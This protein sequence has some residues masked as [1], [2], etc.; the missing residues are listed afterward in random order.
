MIFKDF[1]L[2]QFFFFLILAISGYTLL[3]IYADYRKVYVI[4][5]PF[6]N[7]FYLMLLMS[8]FSLF[9]DCL[10]FDFINFKCFNRCKNCF[11]IAFVYVSRRIHNRYLSTSQHKCNCYAFVLHA[12]IQTESMR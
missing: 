3:Q 6:K 5:L 7:A 8:F 12:C 4:A 1:V 10:P 9:N 11:S 2:F